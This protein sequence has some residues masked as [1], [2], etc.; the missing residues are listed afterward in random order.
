MGKGGG[1]GETGLGETGGTQAR[2]YTKKSRFVSDATRGHVF[3]IRR[4]ATTLQGLRHAHSKIQIEMIRSRDWLQLFIL[5]LGTSARAT[6][7][8]P[9]V[10]LAW[11]ATCVPTCVPRPYI[12][13]QLSSDLSLNSLQNIS[14]VHNVV[15]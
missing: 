3:R 12:L 7:F 13:R 14:L 2:T 11:V 4:N 15:V 6:S 9:F 8:S 5:V 1:G 10:P